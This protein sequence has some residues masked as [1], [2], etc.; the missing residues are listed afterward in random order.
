MTLN[1]RDENPYDFV[2]E[3]QK[4]K[5]RAILEKYSIK[6]MKNSP[7]FKRKN[8]HADLKLKKENAEIQRLRSEIA[9]KH[10]QVDKI[11][12]KLK[13]KPSFK[14]PIVETRVLNEDLSMCSGVGSYRK[15]L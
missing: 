1:Q 4:K 10:N 5:N 3:Q 7:Y 12:G 15:R 9:T 6:R 13:F 14:S 8:L 11:L 2:T